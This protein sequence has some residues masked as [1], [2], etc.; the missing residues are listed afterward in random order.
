MTVLDRLPESVRLDYRH[1]VMPVDF[2]AL[3]WRV[4][5]LAQTVATAFGATLEPVHVDTASPWR[6]AD[7]GSRLKLSASPFGRRL[8]VNVVATA[9]PATGIVDFARRTEGSLIAMTTHGHTG[10]GGL[11]FGS[12]CESVLRQ[13]DEPVLVAGPEFDIGRHSVLRRIV[14]GVDASPDSLTVVPDALAWAHAFDVPVELMTVVPGQPAADLSVEREAASD[15]EGVARELARAGEPIT[16][17]VLHGSRA[18][19]E[20]VR[21]A[22]SVPG[23]LVVM[24][25]HARSGLSRAVVGSVVMHVARHATTGFLLRR[26]P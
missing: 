19:F 12:V 22:D 3:S 13:T 6:D 20:I 24:S 11:A 14:V 2:S 26:R 23:T 9:D 21:Y 10:M 25:T 5:P 16:A 18:G 8:E 15:M 17:L 4:L 7:D 1:V